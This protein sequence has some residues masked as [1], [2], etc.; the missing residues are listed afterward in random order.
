VKKSPH[1][2]RGLKAPRYNTGTLPVVR[3]V[4]VAVAASRG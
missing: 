2:P 4:V 3:R 1:L